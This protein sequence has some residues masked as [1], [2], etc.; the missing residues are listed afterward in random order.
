M[1]ERRKARR[2][3]RPLFRDDLAHD[4][5]SVADQHHDGC[6]LLA[7]PL[8]ARVA[9]RC[10]SRD[11]DRGL[12]VAGD[13]RS[14]QD[15][16]RRAAAR[17]RGRHRRVRCLVPRMIATDSK[18]STPPEPVRRSISA[19][20]P[21]RSSGAG[22]TARLGAPRPAE[23]RCNPG[24]ITPL[25]CRQRPAGGSSARRRRVGWHRPRR[26]FSPVGTAPAPR[27]AGAARFRRT[28]RR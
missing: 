6:E 16:R 20:R 13:R 14:R 3:A 9:V 19:S 21:G 24:S 27:P 26:T 1:L 22:A 18:S 28:L 4:E 11:A 23:R 10:P 17:R 15:G 7:S 8:F 5:R 12:R 2:V 25:D